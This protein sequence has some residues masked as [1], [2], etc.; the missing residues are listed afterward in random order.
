[1]T[2]T[3]RRFVDAHVH[4]WDAGSG[5]HDLS[6]TTAM[7]GSQPVA[8][9]YVL[10]D[11]VSSSAAVAEVVKVVH[12]SALVDPTHVLSET[13]WIN[14]LA[15]GSSISFAV[16]GTLDAAAPQSE[17]ENSLDE[18]ME[19]GRFRGVRVFGG[20][21]LESPQGAVLLR[22]LAQRGLLYDAIAHPA[23]GIAAA[24]KAARAHPE[25]AFVLEHTGWPLLT[26]DPDHFASWRAEITQLADVP[27]VSCKISGLAMAYRRFDAADFAPYVE[28]CLWEFGP[29]RCMV[30]SN[31]PVD[32][33][34]GSFNEMFA[35]YSTLTAT[36]TP[37]EQDAVFARTA[38][39]VYGV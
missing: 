12:I 31:F 10:E 2:G 19:G 38:E 18:Q 36:L 29:N 24:A 32:G 20:L 4:F 39:R 33:L 14:G 5:F 34:Y 17:I 1:V 26:K 11:H 7:G 37:D 23:G 28:H 27:T 30:G 6:P 21:N 9:R 16:V 15:D 22:A 8:Q 13:R 3:P 25:V 35:V